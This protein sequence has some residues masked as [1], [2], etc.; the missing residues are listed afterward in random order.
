M[1]T[2]CGD[3]EANGFLFEAD[4]VWCGVFKDMQTQELFK[5]GPDEVQDMLAFLDNEVGTLIIHNGAGYDLPLLFRLYGWEFRGNLIDTLQMSRMQRP[6]RILPVMCPNKR[7][8]AHSIEAWG[9]RLGR[10]KPSHDEWD[11]YSDAM[12]HRCTEDVEILQL[13]YYALL[14]EGEGEGWGDAHKLTSKLFSLLKRQEIYGWMVDKK[15]MDFCI[16]MLDKW[17]GKIDTYVVPRLPL[18]YDINEQKKEGEYGFV[19]KPFKK[20]GSYSK[21]TCDYF[22]YPEGSRQGVDPLC[23]VGG[24]FCRVSF[25]HLD[26]TKNAEIKDFLLSEGWEPAEWNTNSEGQR[27]S[28]KLSKDDPFVG[29]EGKLGNLVAK[30]VQCRQRRGVITGWLEQIRPDGRIGSV[31]TGLATTNRAKHSVIVNVPRPTTFFG[32]WMRKVFIAKPGWVLVGTDADA[33]QI[34]MLAARMRDPGYTKTILEGKASDG[35]DMHSV[36]QRFAGLPTRDM[37]KTF[38]YGL[39]FGSGDAKT[40]KIVKGTAADGKELKARMFKALPALPALID[41]IVEEW[42]SHAKQVFNSRYGRM[43]YRDGWIT[44][45]DGRRIYIDSEH[46]VLVGALQSDEAILMQVA[47]VMTYK[48]LVQAG[49]EMGKDFGIVTW[50]HDEIQIECRPEIADEVGEIMCRAIEWSGEY[51]NIECPQK[52]N[53]SIGNNWAE[54][55]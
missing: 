7:A 43:E 30:R 31:V 27:T 16:H 10:G 25:R 1:R 39:I 26:V 6:D 11:K 23:I 18:T 15:H 47:Y 50:M 55:H 9:Y 34:R 45:V 20:D 4:R 24:P 8:G 13:V 2:V 5:F 53:Y 14:K 46:K 33:C 42:R 29:V 48:W 21:I 35:T 36:N 32:R 44:G 51:L 52:G 49:Y 12:L 17:M 19:R 41:S 40:G 54:T 38:F 3:L 28:P 22:G 37:A